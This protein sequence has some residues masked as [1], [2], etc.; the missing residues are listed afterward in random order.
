MTQREN[1]FAF[2]V[3]EGVYP[4]YVSINDTGDGM[5]DFAVRS[6]RDGERC[7]VTAAMKMP[8]AQAVEM[9][10]AILAK[11]GNGDPAARH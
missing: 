3:P 1:V 8:P 2:T 7:G 10:R 5:I 11:Y 6:P 4:E 9:A